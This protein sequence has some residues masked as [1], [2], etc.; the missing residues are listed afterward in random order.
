[1]KRLSYFLLMCLLSIVCISCLNVESR[2]NSTEEVSRISV[3]ELIYEIKTADT[4]TPQI[5][6]S[7]DTTK[8][9]E[10]CKTKQQ[11]PSGNAWYL[12]TSKNESG[13]DFFL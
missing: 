5:P 1:M 6:P 9:K 2:E 13:S 8:K 7:P 12:Y 4:H 3:D 11:H 10:G